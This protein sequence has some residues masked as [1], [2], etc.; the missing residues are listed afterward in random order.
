MEEILKI[1][2]LVAGYRKKKVLDGIDLSIFKS[3]KILLVGPNGSGKSTLM[4][5]IIGLIKP[6]KGEI[7]FDG[8]KLKGFT[9][10]K[11]IRKGIGYLPQSKNIFPSLTVLENLKI[12]FWQKKDKEI[13]ELS[14]RLFSIF[15]FLKEHIEKRA[16][17]LSGGERQALAIGITLLQEK[18]LYL[19]DE[20]TAGL[21]PKAAENILEGIK[22]ISKNSLGSI[23]LIEHNLKFVQDWYD[24]IIIMKEGKLLEEGNLKGATLKEILERA[25]F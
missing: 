7:Y 3:E 4:K 22:K 5:T 10:D 18:K 14:E 21:S 8:E 9:T 15:P 25:Y 13:E 19:L 23:V 20:P 16:G 1:I 12:A 24:R 2:N 6:I 11:I 17:L